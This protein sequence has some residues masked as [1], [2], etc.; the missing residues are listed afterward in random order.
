MVHPQR[1]PHDLDERLARASRQTGLPRAALIEQL[2]ASGLAAL[3]S[4]G[5]RQTIAHLSSKPSDAE[6]SGAERSIDQRLRESGLGA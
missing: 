1:F 2:I 4:H 5:S 3:E 6:L